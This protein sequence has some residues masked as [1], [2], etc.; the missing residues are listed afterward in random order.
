M[1]YF[2]AQDKS[3]RAISVSAN[4]NPDE[5]WVHFTDKDDPVA[6]GRIRA[7]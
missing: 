2:G 1:I 4:G 3:I 6:R 7:C 5:E